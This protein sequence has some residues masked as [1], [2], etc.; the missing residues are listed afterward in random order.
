MGRTDEAIKAYQDYIKAFPDDS[1]AYLNL[2]ILY[3]NSNKPKYAIAV[4]QEGVRKTQDNDMKNELA[5]SYYQ[6]GEFEKA[7]EIYDGILTSKPDSLRALFNKGLCLT[8][9][10]KYTE[11]DKIFKK[12]NTAS[13]S[14]LEKYQITRLDI[15]KSIAGNM[16]AEAN[17]LKDKKQYEKA[18]AIYSKAIE[19]DNMNPDAYLGLAKTYENL[20]DKE[21]TMEAYEQAV[22]VAPD[23]SGVLIEYGE[24]L[25]KM[26][27]DTKA[28][29]TFKKILQN[30]SSYYE[31]RI[32]LADSYTKMKNYKDALTEYLE[33]LKYNTGDDGLYIKVGNT[34]KYLLDSKNAI[35]NYNK[36]LEINPDNENAYFN[37]GL[38][39]YDDSNIVTAIENFNKAISIKKDFAFAY[40][41]L[42]ACYEKQDKA[43]DAI[44]NYEKFIE[45]SNDD[46]LIKSTK[47]KIRSLYESLAY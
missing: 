27:E 41:A 12:V 38:V 4:L 42:G 31:A 32:S 3:S 44:Y 17:S 39:Q 25:S 29:E 16:V 21:K 5:K 15:K 43:D 46:E 37:I 22:S 6:N 45:Y 10:G 18:K 1:N 34:Y 23:N 35:A 47:E 11:A 13:D 20:N 19:Q 36:A 7:T 33:A 30:D 14:E 2:G 9:L 28:Q 26:D 8:G 24:S 40:W